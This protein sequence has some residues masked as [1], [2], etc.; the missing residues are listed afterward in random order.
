MVVSFNVTDTSG[1]TSQFRLKIFH[2]SSI[3]WQSEVS[4]KGKPHSCRLYERSPPYFSS[5]GV[6]HWREAFLQAEVS[7]IQA[8]CINIR[9]FWHKVHTQVCKA[10]GNCHSGGRTSRLRSD[11]VAVL[12]LMVVLF[13]FVC[14][15]KGQSLMYFASVSEKSAHYPGRTDTESDCLTWSQVIECSATGFCTM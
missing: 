7:Y 10:G 6:S 13:E 1:S 3:L 12:D 4:C 15:R 2:V 5:L 11:A 14:D 9:R 8:S